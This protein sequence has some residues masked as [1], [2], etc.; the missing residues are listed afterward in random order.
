[1]ADAVIRPVVAGDFEAWKAMFLDYAPDWNM[2][3]EHISYVWG[4]MMDSKATLNGLVVCEDKKPV[5][6]MHYVVSPSTVDCRQVC[7]LHDFY[8]AP[9]KRGQGIGRQFLDRLK[10]MGHEQKWRFIYWKTNA[11]NHAAQKLYD[12][13][14]ERTD[15][16]YYEVRN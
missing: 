3:P 5:G 14:A 8:V 6:F 9:E 11:D 10:Q 2:T 15:R 12:S 4:L 1:M 13:V 7:Y 16:I